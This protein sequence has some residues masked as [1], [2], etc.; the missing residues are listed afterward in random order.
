ML[1]CVCVNGKSFLV[2]GKKS[3]GYFNIAYVGGIKLVE[4]VSELT[5]V[6]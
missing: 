6:V 4:Q 3:F 5:G 2:I 1:F